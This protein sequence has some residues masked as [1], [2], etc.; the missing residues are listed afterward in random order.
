MHNFP[1]MTEHGVPY[2]LLPLP[3][4]T[5]LQRKTPCPQEKPKT[6]LCRTSV[7]GG[8]SCTHF[9]CNT[10]LARMLLGQSECRTPGG[11]VFVAQR[12]QGLFGG[13]ERGLRGGGTPLTGPFP[14]PGGHPTTES[15]KSASVCTPSTKQMFS[16]LPPP[17]GHPTMQNE[18][19]VSVCTPFT[20]QM[21]FSPPAR[22]APNY[23]K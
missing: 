17:G 8:Q 10:S 21:I 14:P 7:T 18:Q 5:L 15:G 13:L 19:P 12:K 22:R 6:K 4:K 2:I 20:K 16:P 1:E 9:A 11:R 3:S 23:A